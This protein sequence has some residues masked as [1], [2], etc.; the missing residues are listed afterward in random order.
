MSIND[1]W[2]WSV[3]ELVAKLCHSPALF[4]TAQQPAAHIPDGTA[5][6]SELRARKIT[7]QA[8]LTTFNAQQLVLEN[9]LKISHPSQRSALFA[10]IEMLRHR[11]NEYAQYKATIGLGPLYNNISEASPTIQ[12]RESPPVAFSQR[13]TGRKRSRVERCPTEP[14]RQA[15]ETH[16]A[17]D[18]FDRLMRWQ[19]ATEN[20]DVIDFAAEE[21]L[22]D[23]DDASGDDDEEDESTILHDP[24]DGQSSNRRKPTDEEIVDIINERIEFYSKSWTP[25]AGVLR[26]EEVVYDVDTMWNEA[27]ASGQRQH[28]VQK[29]ET[30]HA[31]YS[32]RLD[33]LCDEVM[34]YGGS[35]AVSEHPYSMTKGRLTLVGSSTA[36]MSQSRNYYPVN[37]ACRVAKGHLQTGTCRKQR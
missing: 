25:N 15:P 28:L 26:G 3:D 9:E 29:Y 12:T 5:L 22:E 6:E 31:Y 35:N 20:D 37:G 27:E 8:F 16:H 11:S 2:L 32:D 7:G 18:V 19:N 30:N 10:V 13:G 14:L 33:E 36:A 1:P 34:K 23:D 4:T 21:S 17:P 24:N